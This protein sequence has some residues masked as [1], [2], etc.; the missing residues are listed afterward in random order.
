[1]KFSLCRNSE[2]SLGLEQHDFV[3]SLVI[4]SGE[5]VQVEIVVLLTY[6]ILQI[7]DDMASVGHQ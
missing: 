4:Q 1:M 2:V 3:H 7:R 6:K 5:P